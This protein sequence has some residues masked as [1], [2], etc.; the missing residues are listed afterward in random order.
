MQVLDV[1]SVNVN[2][3]EHTIETFLI[4][5]KGNDANWKIDRE[6][7]HEKVKSFIG[8][9]FSIIP[10]LLFR[11]LE[12]GGG[13][14]VFGP[15]DYVL[16]KYHENRHGKIVDIKGPI[17]DG[18]D[19]SYN[20]IV[21]LDNS[22]AASALLEHGNNTWIPFA[23][24][25]HIF[26][27]EAGGG[28]D[29]VGWKDWEAGAVALVIKGAYGNEAVVSKLC[30]GPHQ[31]CKMELLQRSGG[32][33]FN[34]D[35][36][37][38]EEVSK[39]GY[40]LTYNDKELAY[41]ISSLVSRTAS[42]NS[43]TMENTNIST[44][45]PV[46]PAPKPEGE[47]EEKQQQMK[48]IKDTEVIKAPQP[49]EINISAEELNQLRETQK[50]FKEMQNERR[51]ELLSAIFDVEDEEAKKTLI[52]NYQ[53]LDLQRV[54]ELKAFHDEISPLISAKTRKSI[55]MELQKKAEEDSKKN[56]VNSNGRSASVL[57]EEPKV[58]EEQRTASSQ[59]IDEV[60][61]L[62]KFMNGGRV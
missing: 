43:L 8:K 18:N 33:D 3:K 4:S 45:P 24:S 32:I 1:P 61:M 22:R 49:N 2:D 13:G 36:L 6:T 5:T 39:R 23:V 57:R 47:G 56:K 15:K 28:N 10:E 16:K 41:L 25:P 44:E 30:N 54:K 46:P 9:D 51:D 48:L 26:I 53:K 27:N 29:E 11:P 21:Q 7:G 59:K 60:A 50:Q 62:K 35:N 19:Y 17:F 42:S 20:A 37:T 58:P 12:Q 40:F 31:A 52:K 34:K 38:M 14:H 55:E